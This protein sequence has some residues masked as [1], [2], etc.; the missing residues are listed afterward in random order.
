MFPSRVGRKIC[1]VYEKTITPNEIGKLPISMLHLTLAQPQSPIS[2]RQYPRITALITRCD[3]VHQN[4]STDTMC[5]D[6][7][8]P[9]GSKNIPH[10]IIQDLLIT[11]GHQ[12][13]TTL[14][15]SNEIWT[16]NY[17]ESSAPSGKV[18]LI[19]SPHTTTYKMHVISSSII[20]A[21]LT[22]RAPICGPKQTLAIET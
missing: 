16:T 5:N 18:P 17:R 9:N 8:N 14:Q 1:D 15:I 12:I 2:N 21:M 7:S 6:F 3:I 13:K 10:S 19:K 11:N 22:S 4:D 20:C